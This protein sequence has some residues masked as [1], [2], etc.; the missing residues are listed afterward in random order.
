MA[1]ETILTLRTLPDGSQEIVIDHVSD[2]SALPHEHEETHQGIANSV[3]EG[4][5]KKHKG[6]ISI[7]RDNDGQLAEPTK[8]QEIQQKEAVKA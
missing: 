2:R 8:P 5:M 1:E 6:K 7:S 4:G 3:I